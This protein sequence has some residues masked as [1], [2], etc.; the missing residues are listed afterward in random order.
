MNAIQLLSKRIL[1]AARRRP[2]SAAPAR[3]PRERRES[4]H[5]HRLASAG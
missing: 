1:E 4:V 5:G 3:R 2:A